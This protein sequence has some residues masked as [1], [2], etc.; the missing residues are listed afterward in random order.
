MSEH[1]ISFDT[2]F[3]AM[4]EVYN[5]AINKTFNEETFLMDKILTTSE[6]VQTD[7]VS[8][9]RY[10]VQALKMA[11]ATSAGSRSEGQKL[12]RPGSP[13]YKRALIGLTTIS[14]NTGITGFAEAT[15]ND[16]KKA[17]QDKQ[18]TDAL[19]ESTSAA[20]RTTNR[21]LHLDET[22]ALFQAETVTGS[23]PFV[24]EYSSEQVSNAGWVEYGEFLQFAA[25]ADSV[26]PSEVY[27]V[28]EV[29]IDSSTF[30]VERLTGSGTPADGDLV[31]AEGSVNNALVGLDQAIGDDTSVF[32]GLDPASIGSRWKPVRRDASDTDKYDDANISAEKIDDLLQA[33]TVRSEAK[34]LTGEK[35]VIVTD[36]NQK[37]KLYYNSIADKARFADATDIKPG[38]DDFGAVTLPSGHKVIGHPEMKENTLR[39]LRPKDINFI[40]SKG[41]WQ[42]LHGDPF[43]NYERKDA[44][45]VII[46]RYCQ[47]AWL[48][49]NTHGEVYNLS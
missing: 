18:L 22:G 4:K 2:L 36:R 29:D 43:K 1:G 35:A 5:D 47:L 11:N 24:I 40:S 6:G 42:L 31:F 15:S 19:K 12:P 20:I 14:A 33:I 49:R 3:D 34:Y 23:N 27:W 46:I 21:M 25:D 10:K 37:Q 38:G 26:D 41:G 39:V 8:K 16:P 45:E 48:N 9:G 7:P 28:T 32:Q 13:Q 30:T 17:I 44:K